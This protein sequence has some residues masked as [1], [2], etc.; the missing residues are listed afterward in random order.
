MSEKRKLSKVRRSKP[1]VKPYD[2]ISG[3]S[4][5]AIDE[6]SLQLFR[7]Y[8]D[9]QK[10]DE[11]VENLSRYIIELDQAKPGNSQTLPE[12]VAQAL[13]MLDKTK[14]G[15]VRKA[16]LL[17]KATGDPLVSVSASDATLDALESADIGVQGIGDGAS[18]E[19][20]D[21]VDIEPEID[22]EREMQRRASVGMEQ[23]GAG[24]LNDPQEWK[25]S[26]DAYIQRM[27]EQSSRS[28]TGV[29][30]KK[31]GKGSRAE[32]RQDARFERGD[33]PETKLR[34]IIGYEQYQ[35]L[36][37][38]VRSWIKDN[39]GY[40]INWKNL[41]LTDESRPLVQE[42]LANIKLPEYRKDGNS[43]KRRRLQPDEFGE[44]SFPDAGDFDINEGKLIEKRIEQVEGSY[45]DE[46]GN[47]VVPPSRTEPKPEKVVEQLPG[48]EFEDV[49]DYISTVTDDE[50]MLLP[51]D[52][53][54]SYRKGDTFGTGLVKTYDPATEK[55]PLTGLYDRDPTDTELARPWD[56]D[57]ADKKAI[58]GLTSGNS[59]SANQR[60]MAQMRRETEEAKQAVEEMMSSGKA[61][62][63][64]DRP[65][66]AFEDVS[67]RR[68]VLNVLTDSDL[69]ED[70]LKRQGVIQ[71]RNPEFD[72]QQ[73]EER[74]QGLLDRLIDNQDEIETRKFLRSANP[75]P[76]EEPDIRTLRKG[77]GTGPPGP[78]GTGY[79]SMKKDP[80]PN[81]PPEKLKNFKPGK[82]ITMEQ[83]L[84]RST[85]AP[86]NDL[87]KALYEAKIAM[88]RDSGIGGYKRDTGKD[89]LLEGLTGT[90]PTIKM[91]GGENPISTESVLPLDKLFPEWRVHLP[92]VA[93]D[94]T[95]T[96]S[97]RAP[98]GRN[99]AAR[100]AK[101]TLTE[102]DGSIDPMEFEGFVRE[103]APILDAAILE[104]S[105]FAPTT[106]S[107]IAASKKLGV[108][109]TGE[110]NQGRGSQPIGFG[111]RDEIGQQI[112]KGQFHD[113]AT[114][115]LAGDEEL[116]FDLPEP[117][118]PETKAL[119]Q[120]EEAEADKFFEVEEGAVGD[121]SEEE[122]A[123]L[124]FEGLD[125]SPEP[126]FDVDPPSDPQQEA[127]E[128]F[129]SRPS[130]LRDNRL[131]R[132]PMTKPLQ[133]LLT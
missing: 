26:A 79:Y 131:V 111:F 97:G 63:K 83:E 54:D 80:P 110:I 77:T 119:R 118:T 129:S 16:E 58:R 43:A 99:L 41:K 81:M 38:M 13:A 34:E 93:P 33:T 86:R 29:Q 64:T 117:Q 74:K 88:N 101:A 71:E 115:Q 23:D 130:P 27:M 46:E 28:A 49:E 121:R 109:Q 44:R 55:S 14:A 132:N 87:W 35:A 127:D 18:L 32:T 10:T 6:H 70:R 120:A 30:S 25:D 8:N 92:E 133:G 24:A 47:V 72:R 51:A 59:A 76:E 17:E 94:G 82:E 2:P 61:K 75:L 3:R 52:H 123:D 100:I 126:E 91:G 112:N 60:Q 104:Q 128:F 84:E 102:A 9:P 56:L 7:L 11:A 95:V 108:V 22:I 53:P 114:F 73:F 40:E 21:T 45:L 62:A 116:Q 113:E 15:K 89:H 78:R 48:R 106:P 20:A 67:S 105:R 31:R 42:A 50:G 122:M 57:E 65:Q 66:V 37:Q 39:H 36:R 5:K 19:L 85:T 125:D 103:Y 96:H 90:E 124:F 68:P 107:A 4:K 12:P 69:A 1:S 98:S